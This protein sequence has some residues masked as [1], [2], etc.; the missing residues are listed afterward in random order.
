MAGLYN[1]WKNTGAEKYYSMT[2]LMRPACKY[3]MEH[4]HGYGIH[5]ILDLS[6]PSAT[7]FGDVRIS[8]IRRIVDCTSRLPEIDSVFFLDER[9]EH[10]P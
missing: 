10:G 8:S 1:V 2:F 6:T 4:G 5:V 7:P 9:V 3:V